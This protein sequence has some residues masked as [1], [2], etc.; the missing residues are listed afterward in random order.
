MSLFSFNLMNR[1][2]FVKASA[3]WATAEALNVSGRR[4]CRSAYSVK[5]GFRTAYGRLEVTQVSF[6]F[7]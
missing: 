4:V 6:N 5:E 2:V 1:R 3:L 7:S